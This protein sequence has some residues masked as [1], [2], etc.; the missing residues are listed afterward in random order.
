ML[1][2]VRDCQTERELAK[3]KGPIARATEDRLASADH[4]GLRHSHE[5]LGQHLARAI[6]ASGADEDVQHVFWHDDGDI[7]RARGL[8]V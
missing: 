8:D 5:R 3:L 6:P 4:D 7:E 2:A 1:T